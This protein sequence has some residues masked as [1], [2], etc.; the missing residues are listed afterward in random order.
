MSLV[1]VSGSGNSFFISAQLG[2]VELD[3]ARLVP[4]RLSFF[5]GIPNTI[6]SPSRWMSNATA[7]GMLSSSW[8]W[9]RLSEKLVFPPQT[10]FDHIWAM[11]WSGARGNIVITALYSWYCVA[12]CSCTVIWAAHRFCLPDLAS[13]HW[14]HSLC[15]GYFV[16]VRLFSYIISACM[17]HY[18]HCN[19]V[20][21]AW[22]DWGLSGWLTTLLQC[23]DAVGWV[24]RPVKTVGRITYIV[25]VQTNAQSIWET[26]VPRTRPLHQYVLMPLDIANSRQWLFGQWCICSSLLAE[27]L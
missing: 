6:T 7:T 20:R 5:E 23:F 4:L 8:K 19:M 2:C 24:I 15:L 9:A 13:S 1:E 11:V 16:C 3:T 18:W 12:F 17:L 25:L 26:N 10:P 27:C 14:V 22:L 21:W